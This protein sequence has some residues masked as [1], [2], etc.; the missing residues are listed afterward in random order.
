MFAK[1]TSAEKTGKVRENNECLKK[2]KGPRGTRYVR[3][4]FPFSANISPCLPQ[5]DEIHSI[6]FHEIKQIKLGYIVFHVS[7]FRSVIGKEMS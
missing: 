6:Y 4:P 2:R 1:I 3:G 5:A 7:T